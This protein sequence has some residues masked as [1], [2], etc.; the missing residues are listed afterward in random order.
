MHLQR[1][2]SQDQAVSD[3]PWEAA[4]VPGPVESYEAMRVHWTPVMLAS[5]LRAAVDGG[6]GGGMTSH[7]R[8]SA[9]SVPSY[10]AS[11]ASESPTKAAL[12]SSPSALGSPHFGRERSHHAERSRPALLISSPD[13]AQ[14]AAGARGGGVRGLRANLGH[15]SMLSVE[16][17]SE[18]DTARSCGGGSGLARAKGQ[19]SDLAVTVPTR[20]RPSSGSLAGPTLIV[21]SRPP[22]SNCSSR[23]T[24]A[25]SSCGA[26]SRPDSASGLGRCPPTPG[27]ARPMSQRR[28]IAEYDAIVS[29]IIGGDKPTPSRV[30]LG[31]EL[32]ARD[33]AKLALEGV[34]H[35]INCAGIICANH[36]PASFTYLKLNLQDT[37]R[38]D[39]SAAFYDSLDFM[40]SALSSG[41]TVFVHCQHGVSRS[42]TIVI[43]YLMW[44][45]GLSCA[46][47]ATQHRQPRDASP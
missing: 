1:R 10:T 36:H 8:P 32:A 19:R 18:D 2:G 37:A 15:L 12:A 42:A 44:R 40:H 16:A 7:R 27:S 29:P 25:A 46:E 31:A 39:I 21:G 6:G 41:G 34:T 47:A 14:R 11:P 30:L 23:P 17:G 13:P 4:N 28:L 26:G 24:S 20:S 3:L 35:V 43:A 33:G 45:D 5:K 22:S 38:E 9:E